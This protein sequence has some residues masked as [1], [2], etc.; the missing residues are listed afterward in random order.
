MLK[1]TSPRLMPTTHTLKDTNRI[2]LQVQPTLMLRE[3]GPKHLISLSMRKA[4]TTSQTREALVVNSVSMPVETH[5]T[6]LA[7]ELLSLPERMQL[8]WCRMV[9]YM[10]MALADILE[11]L[12]L[13]HQHLQALLA[14][15]LQRLMPTTSHP[16][17]QAR[18][19]ILTH[20]TP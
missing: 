3:C 10:C 18:L 1:D 13:V 12:L 8:R 20:L 15:M 16:L 17:F 4:S 5:S 19:V 9:M 14:H 11:T 2:Q 6:Q 7:L